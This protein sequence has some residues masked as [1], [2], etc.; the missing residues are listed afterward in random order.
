MVLALLLD[1]RRK[2]SFTS[3]VLSRAM[4]DRPLHILQIRAWNEGD[5]DD[6]ARLYMQ[7]YEEGVEIKGE[8]TFD[9]AKSV[10]K[11]KARRVIRRR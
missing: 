4:Q 3:L 5:A 2:M 7:A 9:E 1:W 10:V 11:A 6:F 8:M